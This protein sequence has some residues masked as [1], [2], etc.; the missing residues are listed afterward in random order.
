MRAI[1]YHRQGGPEVL[2]LADLARPTPASGQALVRV[3]A[4]ALN[5]SDVMRRRGDSYPFPTPLP[6]IP[7]SEMAGVVEALGEGVSAPAI[8]T[9]VFGAT[10]AGC[11][12]D[13]VVAPAAQLHAIPPGLDDAQAAGLIVAGGTAALLLR[14]AARL[15]AGES[16]FIPAAA[17]GVGSFVVQLA[18]MMGAARVIAGG[19]T[20]AKREAAMAMGATHAIDTSAADWPAALLATTDG[21]G[22]DVLLEMQ[23]G[24][25]L[26][27]GLAALAPFGRAIVFGKANA[28]EAALSQ[29]AQ[30]RLFYDPA[31]NQSVQGFN[32]GGYIFQRPAALGAAM[33]ALIGGIMTGQVKPP[34]VTTMPLA[35]AQAAHRLLEARSVIGKLVLVP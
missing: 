11:H 30:A 28:R 31:R 26:E 8:G 25:A 32:L 6:Y 1:I 34:A 18:R 35:E 27:A 12:A 16:V 14:E 5:Y 9:R 13:Y 24:G 2:E 23:G 3:T 20:A 33:G 29:A 15:Q 7:G 19:S 4:A 17:G 22:V 21:A 10:G